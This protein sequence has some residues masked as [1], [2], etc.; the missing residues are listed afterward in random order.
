VPQRVPVSVWNEDEPTQV[1]GSRRL[2]VIRR[3]PEMYVSSLASPEVLLWEMTANVIDLHL[4]ARASSLRVSIQG[5][6]EIEIEDDGPGLSVGH[7]PN[8][9]KSA[10]ERAAT[11]YATGTARRDGRPYS[12]ARTFA[13]YT[14]L[15]VVNALSE[16]LELESRVDGQ[17]FRQR[18]ARGQQ[19]GDLEKLGP[20]DRTGVRIRCRPDASIW[21]SRAIDRERVRAR[22]GELAY[23]NPALTIELDGDR[24]REGGGIDSWVSRRARAL[25][26]NVHVPLSVRRQHGEILVEL[27][28]VWTRSDRTDFTSFASQW[29]TKGGAHVDGFWKALHESAGADVDPARGLVALLHAGMFDPELE[30]DGKDRRLT[31]RAAHDAVYEV[32]RDALAFASAARPAR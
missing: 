32:V 16:A 18:Y 11:I 23:L 17:A 31:S 5:D 29:P 9:V 12:M 13:P 26:P 27:A 1:E 15:P 4:A 22:L 25:G 14:E 8:H 24:M 7:D 2:E 19:V 28:L 30:G 20:C 6:G 21:K 10:M 3:K